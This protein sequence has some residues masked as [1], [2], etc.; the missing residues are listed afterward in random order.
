MARGTSN[1]RYERFHDGLLYFGAVLGAPHI[2]GNTHMSPWFAVALGPDVL[3][4]TCSGSPSR[5]SRI[6]WI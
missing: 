5:N 4:E 2:L 3:L 6:L 1:D